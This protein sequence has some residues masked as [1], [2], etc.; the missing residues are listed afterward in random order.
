MSSAPHESLT[1]DEMVEIYGSSFVK[2]NGEEPHEAAL[3]A[4][5]EEAEKRGMMKERRASTTWL[6]KTVAADKRYPWQFINQ[7]AKGLEHEKHWKE[8][9]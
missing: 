8:S 2:H 6:R 9:A 7:L 5:A 4:V 3:Q 1:I